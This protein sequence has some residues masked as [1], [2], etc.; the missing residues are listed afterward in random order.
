MQT[1]DIGKGVSSLPHFPLYLSAD[2]TN[3]K[4]FSTNRPLAAKCL[5]PNPTFWFH[6]T[7]L[8]YGKKKE[9]K[10]KKEKEKSRK[11]ELIQ[12]DT[13]NI[14][15]PSFTGPLKVIPEQSLQAKLHNIIKTLFCLYFKHSHKFCNFNWEDHC[16]LISAIN[17][18]DLSCDVALSC[19]ITSRSS[20]VENA[21]VKLS[22]QRLVDS[23]KKK[24]LTQ[25]CWC[26][27]EDLNEKLLLF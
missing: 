15:L 4:N 20:L 14:C 5:F 27:K 21:E 16:P 3:L 11:S 12:S 9:K 17:T 7:F 6:N 24:K 13:V 19:Q 25:T 1:A 22:M 2:F 18:H 8:L 10:R 26:K 23:R